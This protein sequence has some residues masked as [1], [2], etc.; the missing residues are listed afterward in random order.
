M[1]PIALEV[2]DITYPSIQVLNKSAIYSD[3]RDE[4]QQNGY[5]VLKNV[6]PQDR[7]LHYRQKA[8]DWLNSFETKF[9]LDKPETWIAKNLPAMNKVRMFHLWGTDEL[10]VSFNCLN[11]NLPNRP[12]LS[13]RNPWPHVDQSPNK[14]GLHCVQGIINL[15]VSG[16]DDGGLVVYPGSHMLHDAFFDAHPNRAERQFQNDIYFFPREELEWFENRGLKP[17]KVCA[18]PGDLLIWGSRTIHYGADS[19]EAG[20]NI[21]TANYATY[22]PASLASADQ[23]AK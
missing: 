2:P 22:M 4:L 21:R 17:H 16:P 18:E 5:A 14:R 9:D 13:A 20:K 11:I 10:L 15:S 7:A 19:N 12:D 1:T 8:F 23:L 6:I 3:F